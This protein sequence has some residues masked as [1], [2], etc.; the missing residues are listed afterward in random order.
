MNVSLCKCKLK[1]QNNILQADIHFV[2][3][4]ITL[5]MLWHV[6]ELL[7]ALKNLIAIILWCS[8]LS[9]HMCSQLEYN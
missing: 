7:S 2:I 8:F 9:C 6:Y 1:E 3:N 4:V 5:L